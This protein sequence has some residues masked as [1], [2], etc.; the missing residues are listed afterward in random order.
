MKNEAI[1]QILGKS[2]RGKPSSPFCT[3]HFVRYEIQQVHVDVTSRYRIRHDQG[4][5]ELP[6]DTPSVTGILQKNDMKI[7]LMSRE[8]W[9]VL[10][11]LHPSKYY[12]AD[13]IEEYFKR[14]GIG[15]PD[16]L[17]QALDQ[18]LPEPVRK[19]VESTFGVQTA[20]RHPFRTF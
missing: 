20:K 5:Y 14:E 13:L 18:E 10:Y 15:R 6:F 9:Y 8:D 12:K 3:I 1:L 17:K 2:E 19:R 16:L 11:L 7:H 4:I